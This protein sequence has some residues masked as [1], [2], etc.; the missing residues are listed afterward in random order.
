MIFYKGLRRDIFVSFFEILFKIL[1][2]DI[3]NYNDFLNYY[4]Y[5]VIFYLKNFISIL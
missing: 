2:S 5:S 3:L 4:L 1:L